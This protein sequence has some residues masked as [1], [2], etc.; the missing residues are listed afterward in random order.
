MSTAGFDVVVLGVGGIGSAT[1]YHLARRGLRVLGIDQFSPGHDRGSSHGETRVIR[2]AYFEHPDYV[3]LARTSFDLWR[4]LEQTM[5]RPLL[6]TVGLLQGG[7]E[8]GIV[9]SGIR[10]SAAAHQLN[11]V[12]WPESERPQ[13]V[14]MLRPPPGHA[15][16]FEAAAGYLLVE[17]CVRTHVEAARRHGAVIVCD[18]EILD[19]QAN[20]RGCTVRT[21]GGSYTAQQLVLTLGAGQRDL[22]KIDGLTLDVLNKQLYWYAFEPTSTWSDAMS[23]LPIFLFETEYGVYY[24]FPS[25]DG[26]TIKVARHTGGI[27]ISGDPF[28][29]ERAED[30]EDRQLVERFLR[31][32]IPAVAFRLI[33]QSA[34]LYTMTPDQHFRVGFHPRHDNVVVA[35]GLSGHGFKFAPVLGA[36]LADLIVFRR[37][38][39]PIAFLN[40]GSAGAGGH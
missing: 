36:S 12:S 3:P 37:T 15:V 23:A 2:K 28:T 32:Y 16:L 10:Q 31:D 13:R 29:A 27:S 4:E 22:G 24:G 1:V 39:H 14:A 6:R 34:C 18:Q 11:V 30:V 40:V 20:D 9:V 7:P 38:E 33:R 21:S 25:L 8:S 26:A 19:W 17:Q 5:A 35:A